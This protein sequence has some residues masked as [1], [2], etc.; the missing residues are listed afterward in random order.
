[1]LIF[2]STVS[3]VDIAGSV[4]VDGTT[5]GLAAIAVVLDISDMQSFDK[6]KSR[7]LPQLI[8]GNPE[9][10]KNYPNILVE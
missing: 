5:A 2:G 1:M 9:I 7:T 6:D 8:K 3:V 4:G 10:S